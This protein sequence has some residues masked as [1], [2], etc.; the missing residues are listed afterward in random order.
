MNQIYYTNLLENTKNMNVSVTE[1]QVLVN[2]VVCLKLFCGRVLCNVWIWSC[3]CS[4]WRQIHSQI[5]HQH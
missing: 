2:P 5:L 3:L 1:E 4:S